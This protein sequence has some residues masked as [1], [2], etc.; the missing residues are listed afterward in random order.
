MLCLIFYFYLLLISFHEEY[1]C[2]GI[3][4]VYNRHQIPL[5]ILDKITKSLTLYIK[6]IFR[7]VYAYESREVNFRV[8]GAV[9]EFFDLNSFPSRFISIPRARFLHSGDEPDLIGLVALHVD[10]CYLDPH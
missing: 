2:G 5:N 8:G 6:M 4:C 7:E 1:R 3:V 9:S 10:P